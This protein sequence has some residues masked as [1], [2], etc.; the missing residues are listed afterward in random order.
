MLAGAAHKGAD[1]ILPD[2]SLY[3]SGQPRQGCSQ[4]PA[5]KVNLPYECR[6]P[7]VHRASAAPL[8]G[9]ARERKQSALRR[10]VGG[11]R[12]F[13]P[14]QHRETIESKPSP[15]ISH[16][17]AAS[18]P[19]ACLSS[20]TPQHLSCRRRAT[21]MLLGTQACPGRWPAP[22][23]GQRSSAARCGPRAKTKQAKY[24]PAGH[25]RYCLPSREDG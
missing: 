16:S 8:R 10:P 19:A 20:G 25:R 13:G 1:R 9:A 4:K 2:H 23:Q 3:T 14:D 24:R 17:R 5:T 6:P 15:Q 12:A 22:A 11:A 21:K 18:A 7:S